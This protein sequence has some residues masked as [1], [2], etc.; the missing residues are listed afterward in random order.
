MSNQ[1][2]KWLRRLS[3]VVSISGGA[4]LIKAVGP[5]AAVGVCLVLWGNNLYEAS[6][7]K[8]SER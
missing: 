2:L 5:L 1:E 7:G 8:G 4:M 3:W 6:K